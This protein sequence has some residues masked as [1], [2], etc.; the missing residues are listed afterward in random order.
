[1]LASPLTYTVYLWSEDSECALIQK[2][3]ADLRGG[4]ARDAHLPAFISFI[5]NQF[6]GKILPNNSFPQSINDWLPV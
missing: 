5:F 1:M 6:L 2:P 3:L 4:V